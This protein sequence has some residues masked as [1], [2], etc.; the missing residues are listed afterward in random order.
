MIF[1]IDALEKSC[2][3]NIFSAHN[4][5]SV[6][7]QNIYVPQ[8]GG[9]MK[10]SDRGL[11][12]FLVAVA[13]QVTWSSLFSSFLIFSPVSSAIPYLDHCPKI[14]DGE[15]RVMKPYIRNSL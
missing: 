9:G 15:K 13:R 3:R 8:G 4:Y 5:I 10:I 14:I 12:L 2:P 1:C 7:L 6:A 11:E